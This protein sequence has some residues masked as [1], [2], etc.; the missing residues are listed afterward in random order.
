MMKTML[1]YMS[2]FATPPSPGRIASMIDTAPRRPTHPV[3]AFSR[4]LKRNGSRHSQ[5]AS[6]RA[7]SV[8]T[9]ARMIAGIAT[10][11]NSDGVA[12]RPSV[13]NMPICASQV[14]PT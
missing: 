6:G 4:H 7:I 1:K 2:P 12:R 5:T 11:P 8:R 9:N 14:M 3:K 10:A 13:K